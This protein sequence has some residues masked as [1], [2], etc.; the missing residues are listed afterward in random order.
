MFHILEL[1]GYPG[2]PQPRPG[3]EAVE[4]S[5]GYSHPYLPGLHTSIHI[6]DFLWTGGTEKDGE[7][8]EN[9]IDEEE[10]E[11]S[12]PNE[13]FGVINE[14]TIPVIVPTSVYITR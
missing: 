10:A 2:T 7:I 13:S 6:E 1:S 9:G 11:E 12:D 5:P 3:H 4:Q 8:E 14:K